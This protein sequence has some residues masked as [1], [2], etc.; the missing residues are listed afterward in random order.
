MSDDYMFGRLLFT[1]IRGVVLI[2]RRVKD[3][4]Q[5]L[6]CDGRMAGRQKAVAEQICVAHGSCELLFSKPLSPIDCQC[7]LKFLYVMNDT[8][9][10]DDVAEWLRR[11]IANP[12]L[13]ERVSSNLTVV[14]FW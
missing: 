8:A 4:N 10:R 11:W 3:D 14:A 6:P 5:Q 13:I 7:I 1:A 9:L 2:C 12:L